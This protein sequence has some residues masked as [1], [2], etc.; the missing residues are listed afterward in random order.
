VLAEPGPTAEQL[1]AIPLTEE[2]TREIAA[3]VAAQPDA[4]LA[5][6]VGRLLAGER[7]RR[8]WLEEQGRHPCARCGAFHDRPGAECPAC[9][10]ERRQD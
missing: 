2:D 8:A 10:M 9:R 4:E 7:R 3:A 1:S 5:E 6:L